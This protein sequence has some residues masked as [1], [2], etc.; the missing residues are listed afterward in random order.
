VSAM[1]TPARA[2]WLPYHP[3]YAVAAVILGTFMVGLHGRLFSVGLADLRGA[4]GLSFDEGAWLNTA[5]NASQIL[6]S[7]AVAWLVVVFGARRI[8]AWPGLAFGA[9]ALAIPFIR[10]FPTLIALHA[11]AG[12]L[13]GLFVPA[14]LMIVL[15]NL[16]MP[17][18]LPG[19]S[20]Y[21]LRLGLTANT[22][23]SILGFYVQGPGWEWVYWQDAILAPL[24]ALLVYLGTQREEVQRPMLQRADW[25][26]M[27]LLG[28]GFAVLYVGLDQGNRLAW[29]ESGLVLTM[30]AAGG[31]LVLAFVVNEFVVAEPWASTR[32]LWGR[33][34]ILALTAVLLFTLSALSNLSLLPNFLLNV[35]GLRPEQIGPFLL[36]YAALP[37]CLLTPVLI[38]LLRR[39]DPRVAMMIGFACFALGSLLGTGLTHDWV[40]ENFR[41]IALL[42]AFGF[43]FTFLPLVV[44]AFSNLDPQKAVSFSAYIQVMRL[45]GAEAGAALIATWLRVREQVHSNLIGLHVMQ[46]DAGVSQRLAGLAHVFSPS[47]SGDATLRGLSTL[48]AVVRREANALAYIDGFWLTFALALA[49]LLVVA[50]MKAAPPGPFSPKRG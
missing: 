43:T 15:R 6:V 21:T 26:G 12:V 30:L 36:L 37:L 42:Q 45:V 20:L 47:A 4:L 22:A 28:T 19:L 16:P 44:F 49:G 24:M 25:G 7:P 14:T 34:V 8:L 46:G 32:I 40:M 50:A 9:I 18:W 35:V 1:A 17:W 41:L 13:L 3:V 5:T 11:A 2:R 38:W 23:P 27:M 48:G 33:N 29:A 31:V 10:D 39:R